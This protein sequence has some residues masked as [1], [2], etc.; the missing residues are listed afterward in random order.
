MTRRPWTTRGRR[1][2]SEHSTDWSAARAAAPKAAAARPP[3]RRGAPQ[4]VGLGRSQS[5]AARAEPR[6]R[7]PVSGLSGG[8]PGRISGVTSGGTIRISGHRRRC[9]G[10]CP[11]PQIAYGFALLSG[12]QVPGHA[13]LARPA[14]SPDKALGG[15]CGYPPDSRQFGIGH[16]AG[17]GADRELISDA[18]NPPSGTRRRPPR[19]NWRARRD[20]TSTQRP[21]KAADGCIAACGNSP[22][23]RERALPDVAAVPALSAAV[24]Q[25]GKPALTNWRKPSPRM[26]QSGCY[27]KWTATR[28]ALCRFSEF[29][30]IPINSN[31]N[32]GGHPARPQP[33]S[34]KF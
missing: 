32:R 4:R 27:G 25:P 15:H 20:G 16:A 1:Y 33:V 8:Y 23:P 19:G 14:P 24:L 29:T 13:D 12:G 26:S 11:E 31:V 17:A 6:R 22:A 34:R 10:T 2:R 28:P 9:Q 18:M 30:K 5:P 3:T 7:F 21:G